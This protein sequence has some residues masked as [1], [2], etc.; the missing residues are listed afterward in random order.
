ML[1][2]FLFKI[3]LKYN[4]LPVKLINF[5]QFV[6]NIEC[7][8]YSRN[9]YALVIPPTLAIDPKPVNISL[10]G[11]KSKKLIVGG[12][13]ADPKEFPHMAVVGFD[14]DDGGI[15]WLCGGTLVSEIFVLTAAHCTYSVN[16]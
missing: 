14:D 12:V 4:F 8:E 9:V 2:I 16:W 1:K 3:N 7:E 10:C 6:L 13:K 15:K 5:L 11:I